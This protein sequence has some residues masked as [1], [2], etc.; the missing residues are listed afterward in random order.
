[1]ALALNWDN[2]E[3]QVG[4]KNIPDKRLSVHPT[5]NQ[6]ALGSLPPKLKFRPEWSSCWLRGKGGS[7][8]AWMDGGNDL[9]LSDSSNVSFPRQTNSGAAFVFHQA[10]DDEIRVNMPLHLQSN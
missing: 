5:Y 2:V 8:H 10:H 9:E 6:F 1:M 4:T 7:K 3:S